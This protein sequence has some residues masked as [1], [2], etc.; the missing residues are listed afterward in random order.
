MDEIKDRRYIKEIIREYNA[1]FASWGPSDSWDLDQFKTL[2]NMIFE[3]TNTMVSANTL[4]RFFQQRTG[5]PQLATRDVLCRLLGYTGYIDFVMKKTQ[6]EEPLPASTDTAD[7]PIP[8]IVQAPQETP[9]TPVKPKS[10]RLIYFL[11]ALLLLIGGALLYTLKISDSYTKYQLSKIEFAASDT[12]GMN[13]LT[14]TFSYDIPSG[15]LDDIQLIFEEPNGDTLSK[16]LSKPVGQVNATYIFEGDGFCHLQYKGKTFK[17]IGI[18]IRK[19]GWSVFTRNE[20]KG[21]FRTASIRQAYHKDGYVSMPLDSVVPEARPNHL[22]VSYIFYKEQ[23][24]NGDNFMLEARVRNSALENAIPRS[25]VM[26]Y[27]LSDSGRHG[28]ALN[29]AGYAYIKFIS[30]EKTIMG[31]EYNLSSLNFNASEWHVMGIR[32]ENKKS[33]FYLDGKRIWNIDYNKP[34]GEANEIILRFKGCG[35]VD[36]VKLSK[37]DGQLVYEQD[38]NEQ[39]P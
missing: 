29:E 23:L 24:V 4:K 26:L 15:L 39:L 20:R 31:D 7:R 11:I 13:P 21:I 36:Y 14:V 27:I 19:P 25:D 22:F 8:D 3:L 37:L 2:E 16:K 32:V 1:R 10:R 17:T 5:N 30:G 18:E 12:K 6:K 34:I 9:V 33:A 35:A 28:F 38:F